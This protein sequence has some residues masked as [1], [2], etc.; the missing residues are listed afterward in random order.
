MAFIGPIGKK[1][2]VQTYVQGKRTSQTFKTEALA[3]AWADRFEARVDGMPQLRK[4]LSEHQILPLLPKKFREAME[5]ANYTE[6][7]IVASAFPMEADIGIYFLIR[8]GEVV[9]I[10]Q[11]TNV[12]ARVLKH[13]QLG[14]KFDSFSFIPCLPEHLNELERTYICLMMPDENQKMC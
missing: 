7:E 14:K 8:S 6:G 2:R 4:V 12:L 9:Y 11:T 3:R 13:R 1:W 10:G 5:K